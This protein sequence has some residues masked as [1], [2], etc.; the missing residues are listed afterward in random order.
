MAEAVSLCR[1]RIPSARMDHLFFEWPMWIRIHGLGQ[2][3][4]CRLSASES[5]AAQKVNCGVPL[6]DAT[7]RYATFRGFTKLGNFIQCPG[8]RVMM[9]P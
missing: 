6:W 7:F 9:T 5:G 3:F 2:A 1:Q 4:R 8:R